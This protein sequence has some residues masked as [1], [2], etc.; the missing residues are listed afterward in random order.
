LQIASILHGQ[1]LWRRSQAR[2]CQNKSGLPRSKKLPG[3]TLSE[4]L[5]SSSRDL[6]LSDSQLWL[7]LMIICGR[8]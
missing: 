5:V 6:Q 7:G 3:R 1:H 2:S 8:W 4:H